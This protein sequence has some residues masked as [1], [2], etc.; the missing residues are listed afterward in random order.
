[1][2]KINFQKSS[3]DVQHI[4]EAS[5]SEKSVGYQEVYIQSKKN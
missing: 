5:N 2:L 4:Q 3:N 1:M